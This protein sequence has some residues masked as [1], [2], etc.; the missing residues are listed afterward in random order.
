[1]SSPQPEIIDAVERLAF[2]LVAL[3]T[4]AMASSG[5]GLEP[6]F[7]QWRLL[8]ILG[9][10]DDGLRLGEVT[11]AIGGSAPSASRLVRRM[12]AR[13]LVGVTR[14]PTDGRGIRVVLSAGGREVRSA[15]LVA[16]RQLLQASLAEVRSSPA[17]AAGLREIAAALEPWR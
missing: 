6:T 14:D 8:V 13:G 7:R 9:E 15:I 12:E 10:A 1:V 16:R 4:A 3:T 2:S 5:Q 11:A 17:L